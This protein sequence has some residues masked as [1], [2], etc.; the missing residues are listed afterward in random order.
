MSF[1]LEHNTSVKRKGI[2]NGEIIQ[3]KTAENRDKEVTLESG[4]K[5]DNTV[6]WTCIIVLGC[7]AIEVL[8]IARMI[9][10]LGKNCTV[11]VI[12]M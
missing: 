2:K 6:R 8:A 1:R 12:H 4:Q 7:G 3:H 11:C 9:K 5:E 10:M